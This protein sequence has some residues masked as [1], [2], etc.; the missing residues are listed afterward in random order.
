MTARSL[1]DIEDA[2]T[3]RTG[4]RGDSCEHEGRVKDVSPRELDKLLIFWRHP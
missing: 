2:I 1:A 3:I 4:Q